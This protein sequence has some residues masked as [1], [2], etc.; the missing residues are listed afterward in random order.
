MNHEEL[1][2]SVVAVALGEQK[3]ELPSA[4]KLMAE[5][6]HDEPIATESVTS[7]IDPDDLDPES[8]AWHL[9]KHASPERCAE[10]AD[11]AEISPEE[12][13]MV[14]KAATIDAEEGGTFDFVRYYRVTDCKGRSVYFSD[15]SGDDLGSYGPR[16][17]GWCSGRWSTWRCCAGC[18]RRQATECQMSRCDPQQLNSYCHSA[19]V[20]NS[21]CANAVSRTTPLRSKFFSAPRPKARASLLIGRRRRAGRST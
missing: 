15:G 14:I 13:L 12:R 21:A 16:I 3:G 17:F 7:P 19:Q 1:V 10:I 2:D 18:F 6:C 9:E 20:F 5:L 11:G 4:E 8:R